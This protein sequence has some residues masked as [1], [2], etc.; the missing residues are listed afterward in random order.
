M[1]RTWFHLLLGGLLAS[2]AARARN[3][4]PL[5]IQPA[6]AVIPHPVARVVLVHGIFE[7]GTAFRMLRKRLEN[8]RIECF[9]P[10]LR[11]SDGRGGLDK[12]AEGLKRDIDARFGST[13]PISIVAFSMG[14]LV[15]RHY[16]QQLGGA[17]RCETFITISSP[18]HGTNAAWFYPSAGVRQMRPGSGFLKNLALTES[19]LDG[20]RIASFRTPL[21]LIILP[22]E[23]S[24]WERAENRSYLVALH[25]L[26]LTSKPVLDDIE[27]R[28]LPPGNSAPTG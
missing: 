17:A 11:P 14:G 1:K 19:S 4:E 7:K 24:I 13:G 22:T 5:R 10:R 2:G 26:M 15:S 8:R 9:V 18:H 21:D 25:P 16:L 20:I 6:P 23:S 12:L 27:L 3:P 28:L